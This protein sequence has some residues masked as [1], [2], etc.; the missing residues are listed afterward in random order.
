MLSPS[1]FPKCLLRLGVVLLFC[2]LVNYE[3]FCHGAFKIV[4]STLFTKKSMNI[5]SSFTTI[6]DIRNIHT[7]VISD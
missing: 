5:S 4:I 2:V 7:L 3:P 6:R 1:L